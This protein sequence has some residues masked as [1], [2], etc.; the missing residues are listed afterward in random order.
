MT[1]PFNHAAPTSKTKSKALNRHLKKLVKL[2]LFVSLLLSLLFLIGFGLYI[3][4]I[5]T[6]EISEIKAD[7]IVVLTGGKERIDHSLKLLVKGRAHRLLIT[8]VHPS[9]KAKQIAKL[10]SQH[11]EL[12]D[13][14]VDLDRNALD[15]SGNAT[16]TLKWVKDNGFKSLIIVTS[17][18]H[19]P[20]A[21]IEMKAIMPYVTFIPSP[22]YHK[23]LKLEQWYME[24]TTLNLLFHEYTKL[25][26]ATIKVKTQALLR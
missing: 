12:F 3:H 8:G 16:S 7:G 10:T 9:T 23:D 4:H 21:L 26:L 2:L 20:R 25:I 19:M 14:C 22:V 1:P 15:T 6:Q 5:E 24:K 13:C 17:A 18:Y 11:V